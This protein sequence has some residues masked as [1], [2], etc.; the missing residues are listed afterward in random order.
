MS[1]QVSQPQRPIPDDREGWKA[2]WSAQGM[3]WRMQPEI[4]QQ[5]QQFLAERQVVQPDIE[6]GSYPFGGV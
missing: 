3:P 6:K 2:Y 5:R 1:Q 4:D